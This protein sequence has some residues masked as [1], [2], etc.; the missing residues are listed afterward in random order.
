MGAAIGVAM[1]T[2][3]L[4]SYVATHLSNI[5]TPEQ[6]QAVLQ[7]SSAINSLPVELRHQVRIV[8][9][10]AYNLQLK[11]LIAFSAAQIPAALLMWQKK[12]IVFGVK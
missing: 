6:A 1:V 4:N 9:A 10:E 12:Q 7:S 2:C 8:F 3:I 5:L 11:V